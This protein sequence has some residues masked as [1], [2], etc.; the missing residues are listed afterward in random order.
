MLG[1]VWGGGVGV[2]SD[3]IAHVYHG[4]LLATARRGLRQVNQH[5]LR[6]PLLLL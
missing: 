1:E 4:A 3:I 6:A 2:G 5:R